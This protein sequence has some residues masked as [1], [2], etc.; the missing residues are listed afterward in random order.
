L[1]IP[2]EENPEIDIFPGDLLP[3]VDFGIRNEEEENKHEETEPDS[4]KSRARRIHQIGKV[5]STGKVL[6][7]KTN[8]TFNIKNIPVSELDKLLAKFF[9][10]EA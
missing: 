8:N 9:K 6:S 7:S 1:S 3:N 4:I 2:N 5:L 10:V